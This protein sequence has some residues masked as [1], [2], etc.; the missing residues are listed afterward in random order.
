VP[1]DYHDKTKLN[2]RTTHHSI[3]LHYEDLIVCLDIQC[4]DEDA[5]LVK[6]IVKYTKTVV[7]KRGKESSSE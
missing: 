7:S 5:D 4:S 2:A 1:K 3:G 6:Q